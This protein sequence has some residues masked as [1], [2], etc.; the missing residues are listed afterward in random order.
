MR[1]EDFDILINKGFSER[2]K[3]I[4]V[5]ATVQFE[6]SL[7]QQFTSRRRTEHEGCENGRENRANPVIEKIDEFK[8]RRF[9]KKM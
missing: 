2:Y 7:L 3:K 5:C 9:A 8:Q 1:F 6:V 4:W